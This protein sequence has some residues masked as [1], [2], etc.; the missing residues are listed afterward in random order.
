MNFLSNLFALKA[1]KTKQLPSHDLIMKPG[2]YEDEHGIKYN[3]TVIGFRGDNQV[4]IQA[5]EPEDEPFFVAYGPDT[6]T[7][8]IFRVWVTSRV[9]VR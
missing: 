9:K 8:G 5:Q 4:V 1:P 6:F 7:V 2:F 3:V